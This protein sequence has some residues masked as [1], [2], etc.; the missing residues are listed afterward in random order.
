MA[1]NWP[2]EFEARKKQNE[3]KKTG[4]GEVKVTV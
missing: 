1:A 3:K 4:H 2:D